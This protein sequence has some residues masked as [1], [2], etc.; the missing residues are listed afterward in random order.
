MWINVPYTDVLFGG[1]WL[2][3]GYTAQV[4]VPWPWQPCEHP[5]GCKGM[6]E[7]CDYSSFLQNKSTPNTS[8][9]I[10]SNILYFFKILSQILRNNLGRG[11]TIVLLFFFSSFFFLTWPRALLR[12]RLGLSVLSRAWQGKLCSQGLCVC[13]PHLPLSPGSWLSGQ[14]LPSG[15]VM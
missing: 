8:N 9:C 13:L 5:P 12:V 14:V 15:N 10:C 6:G 3:T 7:K 11:E 4:S 1:A 2:G